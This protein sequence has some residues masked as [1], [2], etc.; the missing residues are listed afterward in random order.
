MTYYYGQTMQAMKMMNTNALSMGSARLCETFIPNSVYTQCVRWKRKP[1]WLPTAKTKMFRVP[2]K[3][4][5]PEEDYVE[6]KRL[7]N[8]Y[9]TYMTSFKIHLRKLAMENEIKSPKM[10]IKQVEE[11]DFK[12][13]SAINDEWNAEVAK[14]RDI[15]LEKMRENRKN[16]ILQTLL[17]REQK[18]EMLTKKLEKRVIEAKEESATFITAENVDAAIEECLTK[19]VNHNCAIDLE[20]NWHKG[21]YPPVPIIEE[22]QKSTIVE[23]RT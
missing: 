8:N 11:E 15:R 14:I 6:L 10:N 23:Q 4:V 7:Y 17:R 3:S 9:R 22:T 16:A 12:A 18:Y 13:C 20:G 1:I 5:I 21:K 19:V 2:Q